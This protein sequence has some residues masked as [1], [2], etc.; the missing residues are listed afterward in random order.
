MSTLGVVVF[1]MQGMEHLAQCLESVRWAD[2]I[3]VLHSGDGEPSIGVNPSPPPILRRIA[4]AEEMKEL[5]Q[6]IRTDWVLH[7]WAEER[8]EAELR[9]ELR[10]LCKAELPKAPLCYQIPI[11]SHLLGRWVDGSLWGPSPA[12]RLS[13]EVEELPPGWWNATER[14]IRESPG[15]LRGWI[16]DYTSAELSGGV[17]RVQSASSLW[18]ERFRARGRSV[19]PSAMVINPL[20]V[21]MRL[22]LMNGGFSNGLAGLTLSTLAAYATFLSGAK[23]WEARNVREKKG[24]E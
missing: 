23:T 19:S 1:S 17:D 7:L 22:L 8:V 13:H 3:M 12:L 24:V 18:A 11:R 15:L 4:P 9:E 10:E 5:Y 6:E 20:R 2:V 21:F 14:R 16:G